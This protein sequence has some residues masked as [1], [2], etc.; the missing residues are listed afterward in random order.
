MEDIKQIAGHFHATSQVAREDVAE[1]A[2]AG[3]KSMICN[4]PD[5]EAGPDQPSHEEIASAAREFGIEFAYVPVVP[6]KITPEDVEKFRAALD[7]LP[8][9]VL[10]Y[11]RTGNRCSQLYQ[12]INT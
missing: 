10:G 7:A 2:A 9:P 11:C 6:G 5:G 3:Y 1:I 4:R 8:Q 12:L